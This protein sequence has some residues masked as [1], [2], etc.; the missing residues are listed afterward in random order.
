MNRKISSLEH[1]FVDFFPPYEEMKEGIL[2]VSMI[3]SMMTHKC[4][5]GCGIEVILKLSPIDWS[6]SFNGKTITITPS[7]GNWN[8]E[9]KSHYWI[10]NS[11]VV[12]ASKWSQKKIDSCRLKESLI[13]DL[14]YNQTCSDN[15]EID[16]RDR[17]P[18]ETSKRKK[19]K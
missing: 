8:F 9:C 10:I 18:I 19:K 11:K 5:C 3:G 15:K 7:I 16:I 13:A 17:K 2:Y 12:W 4:C 14:Y 6:M 1:I